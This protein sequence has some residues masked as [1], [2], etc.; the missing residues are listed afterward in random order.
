MSPACRRHIQCSIQVFNPSCSIQVFSP[1]YSIRV[2]QSVVSSPCGPVHAVQSELF[3]PCRRVH[4]LVPSHDSVVEIPE[5]A[6][7][8]SMGILT[9]HGEPPVACC[10][11]LCYAA[12]SAV[13]GVVAGGGAVA[14]GGVGGECAKVDKSKR[15]T[16][17]YKRSQEKW[18]PSPVRLEAA[19]AE[20]VLYLPVTCCASE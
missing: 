12:G 3:N 15:R 16:A 10:A 17:L 5:S 7:A 18:Q 19:R 14:G 13:A 2:A 4:G 20:A 6:E 9:A 11:V 1:I 8:V